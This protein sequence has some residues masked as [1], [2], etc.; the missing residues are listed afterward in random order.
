MYTLFFSLIAGTFIALLF[1]NLFYR[2]KIFKLYKHLVQKKINF[3]TKHFF[4]QEL[5]EKEVLSRY[6][7]HNE[8]ILGFIAMIRRSVIYASLLIFVITLLGL[9]LMRTSA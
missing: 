3:T 9:L 4:N 1:F 5:L 7:E 6:P 2:V 8:Q